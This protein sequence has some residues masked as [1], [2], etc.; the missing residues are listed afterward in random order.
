[1][2]ASDRSSEMTLDRL[3]DDAGL[4]RCLAKGGSKGLLS[5]EVYLTLTDLQDT[6]Q[7]TGIYTVG[8]SR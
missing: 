7:C 6:Q 1:M 3:V 8:K 5:N 2:V 4:E